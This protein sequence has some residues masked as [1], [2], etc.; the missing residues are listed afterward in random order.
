MSVVWCCWMEGQWWLAVV[1][2][3]HILEG[4]EAIAPGH[5]LLE[6][7][8]QGLE[9]DPVLLVG[10]ELSDVKAGS[11][12][13]V[14]HVGIGQNHKLVLL[15]RQKQGPVIRGLMIKVLDNQD[16]VVSAVFHCDIHTH[17]LFYNMLSLVNC[18]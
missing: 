1:I 13:H 3:S 11:V 17:E 4:S 2:S 18:I 7:L 9:A 8:L 6:F 15:Q 16:P 12:R 14:D 5:V 10:A